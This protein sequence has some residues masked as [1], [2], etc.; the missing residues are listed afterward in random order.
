MHGARIFAEGDNHSDVLQ[1][2]ATGIYILGNRKGGT[3]NIVL[4]KGSISTS[5]SSG[6]EA[7]IR[8][9][10]FTGTI[11]IELKNGSTI[12]S[13]NGYGIY[14]VDCT[15]DVTIKKDGSSTI[16]GKNTSSTIYTSNVPKLS[17]NF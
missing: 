1:D 14:L 10:K 15:G 8:I 4:D 12:N 16:S 5:G 6:T 3:I 11:N 2:T 17:K 7:G 13:T 9:E